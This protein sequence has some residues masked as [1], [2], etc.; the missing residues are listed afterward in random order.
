MV[1]LGGEASGLFRL[2]I[3]SEARL[4]ILLILSQRHSLRKSL[5]GGPDYSLKLAL[6]FSVTSWTM[7]H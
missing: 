1:E 7:L 6:M 2:V 3:V 5:Y 4:M